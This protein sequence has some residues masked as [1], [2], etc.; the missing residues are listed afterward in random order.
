MSAQA[1]SIDVY[2]PNQSYRE[3]AFERW[4]DNRYD[5]ALL[6][7]RLAAKFADKPSQLAIALMYEQGVGVSRDPAAAY[8]WADL[9][10]ERGFPQFIAARERIWREL[11]AQQQ[12]RALALGKDL[13]TQYGDAVAKPRLERRLFQGLTR[14]TGSHTGFIGRLGVGVKDDRQ[15]VASPGMPSFERSMSMLASAS[16]AGDYY[17]DEKWKPA[18]YW[19]FQDRIWLPEGKVNVGA[20]QKVPKK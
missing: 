20:P 12:E 16:G 3:L 18:I 13:Y 4:Q 2:H 9:A 14:A 10:A 7:F 6:Y 17:A 19:T 1:G 11:E 8:A 15:G 5:E